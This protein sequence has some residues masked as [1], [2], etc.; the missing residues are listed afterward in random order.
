MNKSYIGVIAFKTL[1]L[2][3]TNDYIMSGNWVRLG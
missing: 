2:K 1:G 3:Q